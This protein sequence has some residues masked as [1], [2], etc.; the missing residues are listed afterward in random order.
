V[1]GP[2]FDFEHTERKYREIMEEAQRLGGTLAQMQQAKEAEAA[3]V[4]GNA[5]Q[6][7]ASRSK[8]VTIS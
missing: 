7:M 1:A 3:A 5:Q 4:H 6:Q 8:H 2:D